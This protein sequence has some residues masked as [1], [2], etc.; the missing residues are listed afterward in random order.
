MNSKLPMIVGL[1][2]SF[3]AQIP[4]FA[5]RAMDKGD[6]T[7]YCNPIDIDY[8]YMSHYRTNN[9]SYRSGADPAV[10]NYMGRYYMFVTRSHGYWTSHDLGNWKF[11][12]PQSWYF[13]GSNAPAAA[14]YN[15]KVIV[16]GDPSGWGSVIETDNPGLGDWKTNFAVISMPNGVQDPDLFVDDD[17]R[18]YLYE[19]SSNKWPIRGVELDAENYFIPKGEEKD[20][21]NL[22]PKVHGWERFGQDHRSDLDPFI[23]GPWMMKHNG[24]YYLEYGAP[25]TQWNVYADGVYTADNPL[26]P[27]TYAPYNPISYKPGGFLKGSGHGSTVRDNQ[28]NYWHFSTMAISVNYKFE[29][30]LGMYPAGFEPDNGQMYVNTAYGDYPHYLPKT[31]AGDHKHRFTGWMLLSY[32]KPVKT[33]SSLVEGKP[34]V[35]DE[36][37]EGYMLEQIDGFE[38]EKINDE[39]I[40]S[41]WVSA[42][43][44]DSIYVELDLEKASNVYAVQINFQ[45]YK[46]TIFGRPD[47]LRQQ[48]V[49]RSSLDGKT[50]KAIADYSKNERDMPH[51]YIEFNQPVEA[52]YIRYDHV[53]C[54][55]NYLAISELRV[56]GKGKGKKPSPPKDFKV[57][58]GEDRRNANLSWRPV[59]NATGYVVYWGIHLD[60]LN[61]SALMYDTPNYGLRA[62]NADQKYYYQVEAFNENGISERSEILET[63]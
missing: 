47:T 6:F 10:V 52:R 7:T 35:V 59:K 22:D 31:K 12:K 51:G 27:F 63:D 43:N 55:N 45:D 5:Q 48:F 61:L 60:K 46:S 39:E 28:G 50:W 62:L 9:V 41:Y 2:A 14:V 32:K 33:N 16:L 3:L 20:L 40:R 38:I 54:T 13:N 36:S 11:I 4:L 34:N 53:Y 24:T 19:E 1:M 42:T 21:F 30:R 44:N 26:G 57:E 15:G 17:N 37:D 8:S 23:E 29:R 18:V 58:R 25:G 56:F 49:L